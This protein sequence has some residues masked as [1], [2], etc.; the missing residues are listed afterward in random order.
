M[1]PFT[2]LY[3]DMYGDISWQE[4]HLLLSEKKLSRRNTKDGEVEAGIGFRVR[5]NYSP[6]AKTL[7]DEMTRD[8][9]GSFQ[10][11]ESGLELNYRKYHWTI[12][13]LILPFVLLEWLSFF[14][15][16]VT[17]FILLICSQP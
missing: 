16:T 11:R 14:L 4:P 17:F 9:V 2:P 8:E 15:A 10:L 13:R 1:W 3:C 5:I 6:Q 7:R 12:L